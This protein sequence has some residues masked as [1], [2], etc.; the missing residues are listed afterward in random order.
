MRKTSKTKRGG[1]D[2]SFVEA[3]PVSWIFI[4]FMG[5]LDFG[6]RSNEAICRH[7]AARTV[8]LAAPQTVPV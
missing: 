7:N 8:V 4:S 1:S 3:L 5:I 6:F 2:S